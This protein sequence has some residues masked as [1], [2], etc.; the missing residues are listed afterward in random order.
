MASTVQRLDLVDIDLERG[1]MIRSRLGRILG[2]DDVIE[3][4][5]GVRVYRNGEPEDVSGATVTGYFTN[6]AGGRTVISSGNGA[7]GNAAWVTLPAACY[8]VAG[9]F[10]LAVKLTQGGVTSTLRIVDGTISETFYTSE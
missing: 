9:E 8:E 6:A 4:Q 3:N 7:S 10:R 2:Q 1:G 5:F